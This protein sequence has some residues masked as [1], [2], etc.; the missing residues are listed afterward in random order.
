MNKDS[1]HSQ[2]WSITAN[3]GSE[4]T[5][6]SLVVATLEKQLSH[7]QWLEPSL[8][9]VQTVLAE[10]CINAIEY[11]DG[12]TPI[13]VSLHIYPDH[14][15]LEVINAALSKHELPQQA[16]AEQLWQKDNP[17]GWGLLLIRQLCDRTEY[18]YCQGSFYIRMSFDI[19]GEKYGSELACDDETAGQSVDY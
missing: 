17:R 11:G 6:M 19:K 14:I 15:E 18:G 12:I 8:D 10:A 4:K 7:V 1:I 5:V 13:T 3:Y 16:S 9:D 2:Q